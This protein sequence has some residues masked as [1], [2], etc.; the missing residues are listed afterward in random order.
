MSSET[1]VGGSSMERIL[2]RARRNTLGDLL[3]RTRERNPDKFAI[4][5]KNERLNYEELDNLVNQTARAFL[6][7]GISKGDMIIVMSKNS[8]DFV[9]VNFALAR[10]GAVMVPINYMLNTEDIR[11]IIEHAA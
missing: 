11:Y 10:I 5:Y 4:A 9:V 3:A 8:L 6:L 1:N 2:Q 7:D